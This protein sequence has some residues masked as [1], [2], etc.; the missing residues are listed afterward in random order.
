[1]QTPEEDRI[2]ES[3]VAV[4]DVGIQP[5]APTSPATYS[6]AA[7]RL[8]EMDPKAPMPVRYRPAY[9]PPA[10]APPRSSMSSARRRRLALKKAEKAASVMGATCSVCGNRLFAKSTPVLTAHMTTHYQRLHPELW[11]AGARPVLR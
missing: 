6:A 2:E 8:P 9:R 10:A 5:A 3:P 4:P 7:E 11:A 1:M